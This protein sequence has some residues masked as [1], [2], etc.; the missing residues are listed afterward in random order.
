MTRCPHCQN[1]IDIRI[2][3][4]ADLPAIVKDVVNRIANKRGLAPGDV[5]SGSQARHIVS[6]RREVIHEL[7][8]TGLTYYR[9]AKLLNTS[10]KLVK[11]HLGR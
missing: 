9:I 7:A 2:E 4:M 8:K 5:L 6:A 3:P 10:P 11:Y 1:K